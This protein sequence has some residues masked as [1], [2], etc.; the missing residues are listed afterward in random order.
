MKKGQAR[1]LAIICDA[2]QDGADLATIAAGMKDRFGKTSADP[3]S[4][5][6]IG[7]IEA[8]VLS[9]RSRRLAHFEAG[10]AFATAEGE[11][12]YESIK[13]DAPHLL[14]KTSSPGVN[15]FA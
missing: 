10:I 8:I 1:T 4:V 7:Q 12:L 11:A 14:E 9:L 15:V 2:G 5:V 6:V 3:A 13:S